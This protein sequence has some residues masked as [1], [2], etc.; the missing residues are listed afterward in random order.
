MNK[1]TTEDVIAW[2]DQKGWSSKYKLLFFSGRSSGAKSK[3][4]DKIRNKEFEIDFSQLKNCL[5]RTPDIIFGANKEEKYSK[6]AT[7]P[8]EAQEWLDLNTNKRYEVL[9]WGGK[10]Q[11]LS[12]FFDKVLKREFEHS[13]YRI[14]NLIENRG[15]TFEF[16]LT[17][18]ER[19]KKRA[20]TNKAT[21][22]E[23]YGVENVFQ[24][25]KVKEKVRQ[26]KIQ[27]WGTE[28]TSG[29]PE[30]KEKVRQTMMKEYGVENAFLLSSSKEN[31]KK[32]WQDKLGI[33]YPL[34]SKIYYKNMLKN[35]GA[36]E[37]SENTSQVPE[38]RIKAL[39]T[40]IKNGHAYLI[41]GKTIKQWA[42]DKDCAPS[43]L[44]HLLQNNKDT[45]QTRLLE[46]YDVRR[47]SLEIK[48]QIYLKDKNISFIQDKQLLD[49]GY[50][51]DFLIEDHKLIIECDGIYWHNEQNQLDNNY[52]FNKKKEY[53]KL[54]YKCLFFRED[55]INN[56]FEI[57]KSIINNKLGAIKNKIGARKCSI[58]ELKQ[59]KDFFDKNHLMGNGSGRTYAL[60]YE[61][62]PI[63]AL[64]V[65]W[66]NKK[67][68]LLEISRFCSENNKSVAGGFSKL[69][70][71]IIEQENPQELITF[72]DER[73]GYGEYLI[74]LGFVASKSYPSFVWSNNNQT[75]H[76]MNFKGNSGYDRGLFKLWDAG[77][78]KYTTST[79]NPT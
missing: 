15:D 20:K 19:N 12:L 26:S 56:K 75:F 53:T 62:S 79:L 36:T 76:R 46:E 37:G 16:S 65:R 24:I 59:D 60:F 21:C 52:H 30:I 41:D 77:Q 42:K 17:T 6:T 28:N 23:K 2:L 45:N 78:T 48:L 3:F 61:E 8:E 44:R 34:Q 7:K 64:Q 57:V 38:T 63:A 40:K 9:K 31:L 50:R 33:D 74:P 70:K 55:E 18:E 43:T 4:L 5:E 68:G 47:S 14:K 71:Y 66:K 39:D 22:L 69:V 67:D 49:S 27:N 10:A 54:G 58:G 25:S 51:P 73:Y 1:T 29:T 13:F 11:S 72:I 35:T 32:Y